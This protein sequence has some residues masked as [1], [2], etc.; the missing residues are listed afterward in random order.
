MSA[1]ANNAEKTQVVNF[2]ANIVQKNTKQITNMKKKVITNPPI[3]DFTGPTKI[4][5]SD[6][7]VVKWN[8][9]KQLWEKI[10]T[11]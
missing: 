1:L 2:A 6:F 9:K 4:S 10:K 7:E 11:I 3:I 8:H 5:P